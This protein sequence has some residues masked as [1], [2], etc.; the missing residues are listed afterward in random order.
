MLIPLVQDAKVEKMQLH[1]VSI[2][3]IIY[4]QIVQWRTVL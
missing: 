3:H 2:A 4:A 1:I